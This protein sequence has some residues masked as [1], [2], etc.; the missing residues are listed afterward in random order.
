MAFVIADLGKRAPAAQAKRM[1]LTASVVQDA[2]VALGDGNSAR[3]A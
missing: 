2:E 3:A 1:W